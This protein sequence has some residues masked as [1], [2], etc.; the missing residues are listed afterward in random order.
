MLI[1]IFV[2]EITKVVE[3]ADVVTLEVPSSLISSSVVDIKSNLSIISDPPSNSNPS[4]PPES[5]PPIMGISLS[6]PKPHHNQQ[7]S[8]NL[9]FRPHNEEVHIYIYIYIYIYISSF[10]Y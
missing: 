7:S 1:Y 6:P 8:S 10:T 2:E 9:H 3:N 4:I 5:P